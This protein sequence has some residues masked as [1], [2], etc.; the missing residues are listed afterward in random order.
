MGHSSYKQVSTRNNSRTNDFDVTNRTIKV[1][2]TLFKVHRS[3][4]SRYST[5]LQGM[6]CIPN[7]NGSQDGTDERPL[8]LT[9]DSAIA[10]ELLLG[11]QYDRLASAK[12]FSLS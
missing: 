9:G 11:L 5:V 3:V 12:L 7:E 10:W 8:V 4:L 1:Q 2:S 6:L